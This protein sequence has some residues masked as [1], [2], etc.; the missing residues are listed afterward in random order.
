MASS[1]K[2]FS[3]ETNKLEELLAEH[4]RAD[5]SRLDRIEVKIDKLS[6]T[7]V[8]LARAEEKLVGLEIAKSELKT[9]LDDHDEILETHEKRLNDGSVTLNTIGKFFWIAVAAGIAVI[10]DLYLR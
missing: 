5:Q 7:V 9:R 1:W 6:E 10:L 4:L 3:V 2:N 8:S